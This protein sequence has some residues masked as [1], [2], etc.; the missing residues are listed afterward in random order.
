MPETVDH[1]PLCQSEI[2]SLFDRRLFRGHQVVNRLCGRCGLVFQ[3]PRMTPGE[4]D[5]FYAREYRQV[6][7]GEEGPTQKDLFVQHGRADALLGLMSAHGVAPARYL[8]IGCSSGI[9]LKRFM[10]HFGCEVVGVEPGVAYRDY[11]RKQGL[12]V[13]SDITE[14]KGSADP[15]F[16]LISLAHVLE[17]LPDLVGYLVDLRVDHLAPSGWMLIEVPNLYAHDSFEIAHMISFSECTLRQT[18]KKVGYEV[19]ALKKHGAPRSKIL[20]LYLTLLARPATVAPAD[21]SIRPER[22]VALKR[23]LGMFWRRVLQRLFPRRAWV[24]IN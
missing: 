22:N 21:I 18:L 13:Y 7:Q 10:E 8:D 17:H 9:L 16:D 1:C 19:V 3:S 24:P 6:Y 5:E 23:R 11:A 14:L 4:L 2:S 15:R 20:P 12:T